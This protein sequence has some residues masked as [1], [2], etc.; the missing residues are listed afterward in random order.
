M[1]RCDGL[2]SHSISGIGVLLVPCVCVCD[3]WVILGCGGVGDVRDTIGVEDDARCG[4]VSLS[5][6]L[7]RPHRQVSPFP[8]PSL[9]DD[10]IITLAAFWLQASGLAAMSQR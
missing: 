5:Q 4:V 2:Y 6:A 9:D 10:A 1:T 7:L 8:F 3:V